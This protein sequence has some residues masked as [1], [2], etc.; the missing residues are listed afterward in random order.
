MDYARFMRSYRLLRLTN[1]TWG[2]LH[3]AFMLER[4][5]EEPTTLTHAA[6]RLPPYSLSPWNDLY[7]PDEWAFCDGSSV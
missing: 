2:A 6:Q 1:D 4:L 3:L 7:G 5:E